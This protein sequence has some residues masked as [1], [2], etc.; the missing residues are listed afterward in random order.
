MKNRQPP[1]LAT[2]EVPFAYVEQGEKKAALVKLVLCKRCRKKLT[3]KRDQDKLLALGAEMAESALEEL[4]ERDWE[5]FEERAVKRRERDEVLSEETEKILD[6]TMDDGEMPL[7]E[8]REFMKRRTQ[9]ERRS[10][11]PSPRRRRKR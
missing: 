9:E 3:W 10:A 7:D 11:S 4:G 5:Y 6:R 2:L 8:L 1:P